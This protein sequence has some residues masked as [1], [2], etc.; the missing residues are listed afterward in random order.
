[1]KKILLFLFICLGIPSI[2][3]AQEI[4][5][6]MQ[7]N[8]WLRQEA[9][10]RQAKTTKSSQQVQA[11]LSLPF[12]DDFSYPGPYPSPKLWMNNNVLINNNYPIFPATQGVATFDALTDSGTLYSQAS[13]FPFIADTLT[14]HYI[15]L[16][17]Y[18]PGDSVYFSFVY[19]P[20]GRG[21]YPNSRDS[22][23]LEFLEQYHS[24]YLIDTTVTPH[25]TTFYDSWQRIWSASG[26]PLDSFYTANGQR[27][28]QQVMIPLK[29][30]IWFRNDFQFRFYNYASL[31]S[32][33]IPS[34]RSNCDQWNLDEVRLDA[35]RT[36]NDTLFSD[37]TFVNPAPSLLKKYT[38]MPYWQFAVNPAAEM[39][40]SVEILISNT[41]STTLVCHYKF[42]VDDASGTNVYS[43]DGGNW[44]L[45]PFYVS[46][47]QTHKPHRWP[48]FASF[49]YPVSASDSSSFTVT[50]T[51][52]RIG[53]TQEFNKQN[54]TLRLTQ[55]FFNYYAYDDGSPEAGYGLSPKGAMLAY[56]FNLQ[57][58]DTLRGVKMFF[59]R[60]IDEA[61]QRNF[62]L[63]A[64][65]DNAGVPGSIIYQNLHLLKPLYTDSLNHFA[66]YLF[67]SESPLVL[68]KDHLT[69]YVGW[70]QQS[71]D[72]L[73]VGFDRNSDAS[74]AILYNIDGS[75][76]K[77]DFSGALM[78]RPMLGPK[79][80]ASGKT[81]NP[82]AQKLK[83]IP[84]PAN[85]LF[86][87]ELPELPAMPAGVSHVFELNI[88]TITGDKIAT[89]PYQM[90][91]DVSGLQSGVY[92]VRLNTTDG[93]LTYPGK[94]IITK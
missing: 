88:Y 14:S 49:N 58:A 85:G 83:I 81:G 2:L 56:R 61:N 55:H 57:K 89:F 17:T 92:I 76:K 86:Y 75:W 38:S 9:T 90:Q 10:A 43:Y 94:L 12:L 25:D 71:D 31:A 77:T 78:I 91:Y 1:M 47:Y 64:W 21:N 84:N 59:N 6:G 54:D 74:D 53:A 33:N 65:A 29:N 13:A 45:Q 26:L 15:D 60:V 87:V 93:Y 32:A 48:N 3:N 82:S 28:N 63:T 72:N 4:L 22:L 50:H 41:G 24:S 36:K 62:A 30:S 34:W 27:W 79:V 8:P 5:S 52:E 73:N 42:H 67:D 23:V 70:V 19:Q 40:D 35:G 16:S 7:E 69:F 20:Q 18:S 11:P 46:G 51:I 44:N 37:M 80:I 68:D 39:Q 66:N